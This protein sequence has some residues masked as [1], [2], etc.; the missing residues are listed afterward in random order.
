MAAKCHKS[1]APPY[2]SRKNNNNKGTK[3]SSSAALKD[4]RAAAKVS[5]SKQ[6]QCSKSDFTLRSNVVNRQLFPAILYSVMSVDLYVC[7]SVG[8]LAYKYLFGFCIWRAVIK[9]R[10]QRLQHFLTVLMW[11][12][13]C[14]KAGHFFCLKL[15]CT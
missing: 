7:L 14:A 2:Q 15:I 10:F 8:H 11:L 9:V 12:M 3:A 5:A 1:V 4:R 6:Q 13:F